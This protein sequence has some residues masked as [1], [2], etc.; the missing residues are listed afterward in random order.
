MP[1]HYER[2]YLLDD[3]V[4]RMVENILLHASLLGRIFGR[5][6][7]LVGVVCPAFLVGLTSG[8]EFHRWLASIILPAPLLR[9]T[10]GKCR[11]R[12]DRRFA[13]SEIDMVDLSHH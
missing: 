8:R 7:S 2:E 1:T 11:H 4:Y 6:H 9:L 5:N 3:L 12:L 13:R 10:F